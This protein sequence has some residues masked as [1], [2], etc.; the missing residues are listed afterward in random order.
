MTAS[1]SVEVRG[2]SNPCTSPSIRGVRSSSSSASS[3]L[4]PSGTVTW[5][6][7]MS[8]SS[9]RHA[10]G[11]PATESRGPASEVIGPAGLC[12]PGIHFG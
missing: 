1:A 4:A 10:S 12:R 5:N 7:Y 11:W 3:T 6:A 2:A 9:R 8:T